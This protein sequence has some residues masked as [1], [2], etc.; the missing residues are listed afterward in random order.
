MGSKCFD[1]SGSPVAAGVTRIP[2]TRLTARTGSQAPADD[3]DP[4]DEKRRQRRR[5]EYRDDRA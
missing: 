1:E 5:R 3:E 4:E 2:G